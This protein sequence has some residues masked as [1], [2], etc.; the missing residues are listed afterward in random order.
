M[1]ALLRVTV[2]VSSRDFGQDLYTISAPHFYERDL[3]LDRV[4]LAL[5]D[6]YLG[7]GPFARHGPKC[8]TILTCEPVFAHE[9]QGRPNRANVSM[10]QSY[11]VDAIDA[12]PHL[13][14]LVRWAIC[15]K[16]A[17]SGLEEEARREA[18][19]TRRTVFGLLV[20]LMD[21]RYQYDVAETG[22]MLHSAWRLHSARAVIKFAMQALVRA[23]NFAGGSAIL[24]LLI[25]TNYI[26]I[27]IEYDFL[28]SHRL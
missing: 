10:E 23:A 8:S 14:M 19:A 28:E 16:I 5:D 15:S 27:S 6:W 25:Q 9:R 2:W 4:E 22:A 20:H 24:H 11:R 7:R 12:V 13:N 26:L 3:S 1:R 21:A 18:F 17:I